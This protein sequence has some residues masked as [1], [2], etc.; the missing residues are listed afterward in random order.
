M[1]N[2]VMTE[3]SELTTIFYIN[4]T[5]GDPLYPPSDPNYTTL[6]TQNIHSKM[7]CHSCVIRRKDI[8]GPPFLLVQK[9]IMKNLVIKFF[10]VKLHNKGLITLY[11]Y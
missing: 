6:A 3:F 1:N 8:G 9:R 4:L 10:F 2:C 7:S 5:K 11:T